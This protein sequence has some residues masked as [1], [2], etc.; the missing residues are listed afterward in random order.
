MTP[1]LLSQAPCTVHYRM[2]SRACPKTPQPTSYGDLHFPHK[3]QAHCMAQDGNKGIKQ[4]VQFKKHCQSPI[5][6]RLKRL[7]IVNN[8]MISEMNEL[9]LNRHDPCDEIRPSGRE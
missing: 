9:R 5:K 6:D 1:V 4:F 7:D 2:E 3:M 8:P